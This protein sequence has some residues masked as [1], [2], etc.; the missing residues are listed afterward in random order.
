MITFLEVNGRDFDA[1]DAEVVAEFQA[2]AD[3]SESEEAL[4]EWV[5]EHSARRG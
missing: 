5:R 1:A 3:G 2:L 4:A